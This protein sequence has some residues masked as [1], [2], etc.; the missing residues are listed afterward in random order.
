HAVELTKENVKKFGLSNVNIIHDEAQ[1]VLD[2][3]PAADAI[4]IGGTGGDTYK[5]IK[6]AYERLKNGKRLV[7]DAILLETIYHSIMALRELTTKELDIVQVIISKSRST[8]IGTM[9]L[10]RNP[11][12]IISV[13]K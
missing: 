3:L 6:H 1:N 2:D 11:V 10:S 7:I 12:T 8:S 5:I 13:E 9:L 4:F